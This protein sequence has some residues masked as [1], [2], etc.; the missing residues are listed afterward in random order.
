MFIKEESFNDEAIEN[1]AKLICVAARTSPKTRG[2]DV[3]KTMIVRGDSVKKIADKM[4]EIYIKTGREAFNRNAESV[5]K[6]PCIVLIGASIKTQGLVPCGYCGFKD[7]AENEKHGAVCAYNAIDLGIAVGSAVGAAAD[8]RID[9][10]LMW[11]V[12]I[13]AKELRVFEAGV[14][15]I[16]GIPLSATGK[17]IF[18]D[19][20]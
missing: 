14:S 13:A 6:S 18:F 10:R 5:K 1:I 16:L 17:N 15:M 9:N 11:T 3:I 19:R 4:E 7:C 20:K 2:I 12:G 8:F